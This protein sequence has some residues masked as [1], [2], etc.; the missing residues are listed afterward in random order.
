MEELNASGELSQF[1]NV[2]VESVL[3]GTDVSGN[4]V[5][6]VFNT[7]SND[8][9]GGLVSLSVGMDTAGV[10]SAIRLALD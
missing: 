10:R 3:A 8:S 5:G 2:G 6:Y 4:V 7:Y 1:G 9:Y